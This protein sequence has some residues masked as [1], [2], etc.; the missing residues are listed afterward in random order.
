[1]IDDY[2]RKNP[3]EDKSADIKQVQDDNDPFTS[4]VIGLAAAKKLKKEHDAKVIQDK[5]NRPKVVVNKDKKEED[6]E[7][8]KKEE[9]KDVPANARPQNVQCK[10]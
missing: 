2:I 1:M 6:K 9:V 4:K 10:N 7:E 5:K 3:S 8:E